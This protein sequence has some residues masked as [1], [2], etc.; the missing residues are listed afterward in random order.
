MNCASL[1]DLGPRL[2]LHL[3]MD[4]DKR[5]DKKKRKRVLNGRRKGNTWQLAHYTI[6]THPQQQEPGTGKVG[7]G[8]TNSLLPSGVWH[9]GQ[10]AML[11][12][13]A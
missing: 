7:S 11:G 10:I 2:H 12:Q 4:Q 13:F 3:C 5:G 6:P 8:L 9:F 1:K